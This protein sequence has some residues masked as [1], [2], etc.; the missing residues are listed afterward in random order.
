MYLLAAKVSFFLES[1]TVC[2]R[3]FIYFNTFRNFPLFLLSVCKLLQAY[4][5]LSVSSLISI[6]GLMRSYR[7][8]YMASRMG[9]LT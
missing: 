8:L 3:I 5:K 1:C 6:C 4:R 7:M 2:L 9:M